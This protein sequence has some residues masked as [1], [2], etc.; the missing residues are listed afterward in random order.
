[1][2]STTEGHRIS[3]VATRTGFSTSALR[4]YEE[5]GLVVPARSPAGYRMYDDRAMERLRFIARGKDLGLSLD[6]IAELLPAW[7]GDRCADVAVRLGVQVS[8]KLA[9][10]WARIAVL[11]DFAADLERASERLAEDAGDGPCG[12]DCACGPAARG[13][14][15]LLAG[16]AMPG[17]APTSAPSSACTLGPTD[18]SARVRE[19]RA[20]AAAAIG[21]DAMSDG[22]R[23]RYPE[24]TD[25][26]PIA[27][28][29]SA[30]LQCC[31]F[32]T[33]RITVA[34]HDV[35]LDI[36]APPG[37]QPMVDQLVGPAS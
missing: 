11:T 31:S 18:M 3:E 12:D 6:E 5:A 16:T 8:E 4:F 34:A 1:V 23:L 27:S 2:T 30:E 22:V 19:W 15:R 28:L 17:A 24:G 7:D 29:I 36:A 33:F 13:G 20:L 37:G 32:F 9:A 35:T 21:R 10:T 25:V 26:G 14:G